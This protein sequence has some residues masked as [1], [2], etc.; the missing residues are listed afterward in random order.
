MLDSFVNVLLTLV[1]TYGTAPVHS[2]ISSVAL[3]GPTRMDTV[4]DRGIAMLARAAA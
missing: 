1:E 3:Y 4:K 2:L